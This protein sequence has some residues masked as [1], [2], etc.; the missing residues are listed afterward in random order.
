MVLVM[1]LD[2][3]YIYQEYY[4][5]RNIFSL[6]LRPLMCLNIP[7]FFISMLEAGYFLLPY[8]L[9]HWS[10][11]VSSVLFSRPSLVLTTLFC[12][13]SASHSPRVLMESASTWEEIWCWISASRCFS[14][15]WDPSSQVQATLIALSS[16]LSSQTHKSTRNSAQ[17]LGLWATTSHSV[18]LLPI[19]AASK[20]TPGC[21]ILGSAHCPFLPLETLDSEVQPLRSF[22]IPLNRCVYVCLVGGGAVSS[23][24]LICV[25]GGST[26]YCVIT[27][28]VK[29]SPCFSKNF[30]ASEY[31][32][33]PE[34]LNC[35]CN[36][37]D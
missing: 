37:S 28:N 35:H 19:F 32:E 13:V 3:L 25:E 6:H 11:A 36:P 31:F 2:F 16:V 26:V 15:L 22:L 8:L 34:P 4:I 5:V 30:Q 17:K 20:S 12:W 1:V 14:S 33:L 7:S 18:S 24:A 10:S 21:H 23:P 9:D 29:A 27:R